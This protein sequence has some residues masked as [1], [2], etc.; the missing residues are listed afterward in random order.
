M[1]REEE[2]RRREKGVGTGRTRGKMSVHTLLISVI[3]LTAALYVTEPSLSPLV[4]S[5]HILSTASRRIS[6]CL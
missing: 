6:A 1:V 4:I 3:L 2:E 5:V